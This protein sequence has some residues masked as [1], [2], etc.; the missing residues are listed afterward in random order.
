MHS[1]GGPVVMLWGVLLR[2]TTSWRSEVWQGRGFGLLDGS[3][4][5]VA[6]ACAR[7]GLML[8]RNAGE[9]ERGNGGD[10]AKTSAVQKDAYASDRSLCHP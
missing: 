10:A 8:L 3:L 7:P 2:A 9:V 4:E 5:P 1:G 6:A